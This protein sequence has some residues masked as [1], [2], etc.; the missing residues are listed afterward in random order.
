MLEQTGNDHLRINVQV[1]DDVIT[2]RFQIEEG[3]LQAI[4]KAVQMQM[5]GGF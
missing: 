3:I 1:N 2:Y 5:A 4:G